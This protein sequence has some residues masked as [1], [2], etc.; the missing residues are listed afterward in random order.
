MCLV[1]VVVALR[2]SWTAHEPDEY[3]RAGDCDG[4]A[5]LSHPMVGKRASWGLLLHPLLKV[6]W[7][8]HVEARRV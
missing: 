3:G 7:F 5:N 2:S 6:G 8:N 1:V 4:P